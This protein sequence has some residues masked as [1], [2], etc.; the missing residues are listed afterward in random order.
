MSF[1]AHGHAVDADRVVLV[2]QKGDL[3]LCSDTVRSGNGDGTFH[4]GQ[5]RFEHSAKTAET[6]DDSGTERA[7]HQRLDSFDR[8]ITC[9]HVN[10]PAA[11]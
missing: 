4:F 6:A 10:N 1:T 7:F 9:R 2:H 5:I 11:A 8:F 3:Q